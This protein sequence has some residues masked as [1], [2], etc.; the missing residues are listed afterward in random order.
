MKL[1]LDC[2]AWLAQPHSLRLC[3][4]AGPH[5]PLFVLLGT[6]HAS[7]VAFGL[8]DDSVWKF[9]GA[10]SS[11][12]SQFSPMFVC[13]WKCTCTQSAPWTLFITRC[14]TAISQTQLCNEVG[15]SRDTSL[16]LLWG[17]YS[18]LSHPCVD[19]WQGPIL[20]LCFSDGG[21][22]VQGSVVVRLL[23]SLLSCCHSWEWHGRTTAPTV[24]KGCI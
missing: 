22:G 9:E 8:Q 19:T 21:P 18:P 13:I 17:F 1:V 5:C 7:V 16:S 20:W 3:I 2:S 15:V 10:S 12:D 14:T 11:L 6:F 24:D 23:P 4:S